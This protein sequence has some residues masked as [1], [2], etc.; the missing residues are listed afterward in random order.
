MAGTA[1][2][3]IAVLGAVGAR[4]VSI[5]AV[6][7][8]LPID[9]NAIYKAAGKLVAR[10]LLERLEAGIYQL[11]EAGRHTIADGTALA[12]GPFRGRRKYP[13]PGNTLAQRA[14]TAARLLGRFSIGDIATLVTREGE[15]K[16]EATL[17][18]LF[19]RLTRG[20]YLV[21]LP[22]RKVTASRSGTGCKQWRLVRDTG[23]LSPMSRDGGRVLY[24]RNTREVFP[25]R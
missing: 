3:Q 19:H 21:E 16:T 1:T 6:I 12:C 9:R 25:C 15:Q 20:G 23:P 10:G 7:E 24:D 18:R 4:A 13:A 14:W 5:D 17:Q 11:T 22:M 2:H 8:A